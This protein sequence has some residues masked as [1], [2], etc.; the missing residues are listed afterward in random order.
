VQS[1]YTL[2]TTSKGKLDAI[3]PALLAIINNIAAYVQNL[4]RAPSSKLLQLFAS[5]SSPSFL[6]ANESN[7]TLLQSL[8]EAM[9]AIVEHQYRSTSPV[10]AEVIQLIAGRQPK[11][12]IRHRPI[13]Q[14]LPSFTKLHA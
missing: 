13:A 12:R 9:N 10:H 2:L 1:I 3:Y 7:H 5:M 14:T 8:L 6:L 11:S 4:G